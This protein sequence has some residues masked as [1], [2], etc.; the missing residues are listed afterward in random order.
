MRTKIMRVRTHRELIRLETAKDRFEYLNLRGNV[1]NPTFGSERYL[2]QKFY[3]SREWRQLR[4]RVIVRDSGCDMALEG[5]EIHDK[6]II[7][8][9]NP[10]TLTDLLH[11]NDDVFDPEYLICVSHNTHNAIHYG[12]ISLLPILP[13]DRA[14]GDTKLW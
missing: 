2:N 1:G 11:G 14:P 3:T 4:H 12:D 13:A 7:H 9:M 10:V 5:F 8:H 6:I